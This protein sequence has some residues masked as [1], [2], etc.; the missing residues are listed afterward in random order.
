MSKIDRLNVK[1]EKLLSR[2]VLEVLEV[3][4]ETVAEYQDKTVRTQKENLSLKR[5]LQELQEKLKLVNESK[6]PSPL[7]E[8]S[9]WQPIEV[10][11]ELCENSELNNIT[12]PSKPYDDLD[13][14]EPFAS[15]T[16]DT[17]HNH[18]YDNSN[19]SVS[20]ADASLA[21]KSPKTEADFVFVSNEIKTESTPEENAIIPNHFHDFPGIGFLERPTTDPLPSSER[22][23]NNDPD[24]SFIST[25]DPHESTELSLIRGEKTQ[26]RYHCSFCGRTFK[27]AGDFKKHYRVHTGE[28]P[29][30]CVYCGKGFVQ[31]GCLK[32]HL[33]SHTGERPFHCRRCGKTFTHSGNMKK[34]EQTCN[35]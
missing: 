19:L 10:K 12:C 26:G 8:N 4:R 1:V 29:Y 5:K 7:Q 2:A 15:M 32:V 14:E 33:R 25:L 20:A 31:S 21:D 17:F 24:T 11:E 13:C 27:H 30:C 18:H 9:D 22:L 3:V 6:S 16:K 34:H 28:K 23:Y 35:G